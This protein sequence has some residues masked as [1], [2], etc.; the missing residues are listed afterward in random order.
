M[1]APSPV[2]DAAAA[3]SPSVPTQS[4][5][6]SSPS[7][8]VWTREQDKQFETALNIHDQDS[9]KRWE[10]IAAMVPGKDATDV[11]RHFEILQEDVSLIDAGRIALPNYTPSSLSTSE[12][13]GVS[14]NNSLGSKKVGLYHGQASGSGTNANGS[15]GSSVLG[16]GVSSKSADQERR[17]GIPWSEEEHRLFLLGLAKFGKGDWRSISRNFVISR[18][19]TQVAS[20]AQKYFIRLNSINKDKR[21]SSIHDITSVN[22]GGGDTMQGQ[23]QQGPITGQPALGPVPG[24]PVVSQPG[25]YVGPAPAMG[26]PVMLPPPGHVPFGARGHVPRPGMPGP[27]MPLPHMAYPMPQSSMHH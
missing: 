15:N 23:G 27:T 25:M 1:V 22:N 18:T 14:D 20:H 5:L 16:K 19:P 7:S 26:S 21:R 3:A 13:A 12:E 6:A 17:K 2:E 24:Q 10:N 9:P 4:S 8:S 11:K